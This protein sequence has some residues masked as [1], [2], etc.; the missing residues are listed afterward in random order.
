MGSDLTSNSLCRDTGSALSTIEG[1]PNIQWN[2]FDFLREDVIGLVYLN[3]YKALEKY[4]KEVKPKDVVIVPFVWI[5]NRTEAELF[6]EKCLRQGYEGAVFRD[7][8]GLHKDGRATANEAT[9][10]RLKPSSDKEALVLRLVE[11]QQNLNEKKKN[12]LGLSER[13]THKANKV[14]KGMLG[15][16]ECL[17]LETKKEIDV[18]PGKM[19]HEERIYFWN[20]PD[21]LIQHY[22]KYRSMDK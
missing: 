19:T 4:I 10:G 15:M 22:I 12:A 21:K 17:D 11:A 6:Y 18:G 20:H 7:P 13:S 16:M 8:H 2:A 3:R 14:G 5:K 1:E 9:Y